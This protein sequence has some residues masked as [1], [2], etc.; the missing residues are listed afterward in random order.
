M[1]ILIPITLLLIFGVWAWF[2]HQQ[3]ELR[4]TTMMQVA[5][6][7]NL[8]F[9]ETDRFELAKQLRVFESFDL[10]PA[11]STGISN[12]V[13]G[14]INDVE[15]F[16]FDHSYR[17]RQGRDRTVSQTT[18]AAVLKDY[19]VPGFRFQH[20]CWYQMKLINRHRMPGKRGE[21][22]YR[23]Q[24]VEWEESEETAREKLIPELRALL[25]AHAPANIEV[26]EGYLLIYKPETLLN[27]ENTVSF[28]LDCCALTTL[29][30]SAQE[31]KSVY[32]W[33]EIQGK[34]Y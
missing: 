9:S 29:L 34:D 18:F 20:D 19:K 26:R 4:R 27:A 3:M 23:E 15:V 5:K 14:L 13:P 7:M 28:F 30:Q 2:S 32:N 24:L 22:V 8:D 21:I 1:P 33:A 6:E 25:T 12:V 11:F 10:F 17:T 16:V 31:R